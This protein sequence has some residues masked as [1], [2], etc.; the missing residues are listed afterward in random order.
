M[1]KKVEEKRTAAPEV[2]VQ[3]QPIIKIEPGMLI[4][5]DGR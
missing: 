1:D 3:E 4:V 5:L 2:Q